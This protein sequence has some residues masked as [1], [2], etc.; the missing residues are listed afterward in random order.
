MNVDVDGARL[1]YRD[2][3]GGEPLVLVHGSASDYRTWRP[4]QDALAERFRVIAYS[5]RYHW[6]NEP[7]PEGADYSMA[8]HVEDLREVLRSLDAEPAHLVGH[9]YG[10]FL[11]LLLAMRE[12]HLVRTLVL[13]EPPVI[14]L[15]VSNEPRPAELLKLLVTRPRTALAI[16]RFG[17]MGVTPATRAFERGDREAAIETFGN[18]VLGGGGY[19]ALSKARKAQ[20]RDNIGNV[21]AELLGSGFLRLETDRVRSVQAP[22]LLVTGE[23]SVDLLHLLTDRLQELLPNTERVEIPGGSHIM[24]EDNAPAFNEAVLAFATRHRGS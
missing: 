20:V 11:C 14:T 2:D 10:A 17:A 6:P 16:I 15:F 24:H 22:V 9:S 19:E 12:P 21:E 18:A 5:R 13:A 1:E 4:Q 7:I 3:G 8:E 23:D